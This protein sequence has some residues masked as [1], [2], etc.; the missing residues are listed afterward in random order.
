MKI[1]YVLIG[2][3]HTDAGAHA[4]LSLLFPGKRPISLLDVGCGPGAWLRAAMDLGVQDAV[5]VDGLDLKAI[6]SLC[7]RRLYEFTIWGAHS[8]LV[9]RSMS[10]S[11]LR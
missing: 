8:I 6:S 5:G 9:A 11:A 2:N 1:D 4:A 7:P 10:R 3:S